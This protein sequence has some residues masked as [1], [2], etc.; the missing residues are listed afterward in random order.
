MWRACV[1]CV[2]ALPHAR[3]ARLHHVT[4]TDRGWGTCWECN[5][6][7]GP[8]C[9]MFCCSLRCCVLWL[10]LVLRVYTVCCSP[11][12]VAVNGAV[13]SSVAVFLI[14]GHAW[15]GV[16]AVAAV[17]HMGTSSVQSWLVGSLT[18]FRLSQQHTSCDGQPGCNDS[19]DHT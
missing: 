3:G 7:C 17:S 13:P 9:M 12:G 1:Q 11:A 4:G 10:Y 5:G 14:K 18:I 15:Y 2:A 16:A 19:E 6:I 8:V